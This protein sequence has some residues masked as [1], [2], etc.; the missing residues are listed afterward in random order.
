MNRNDLIDLIESIP[1]KPYTKHSVV[2]QARH[3]YLE[4]LEGKEA[5]GDLKLSLAEATS[6]ITIL[7]DIRDPRLGLVW[8]LAVLLGILE[9]QGWNDEF[10]GREWAYWPKEYATACGDQEVVSALKRA[11]VFHVEDPTATWA[12]EEWQQI[13]DEINT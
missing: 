9:N 10:E 2:A 5:I 8:A 6:K 4:P 1:L 3:V 13:L 12:D 11:I 7:E